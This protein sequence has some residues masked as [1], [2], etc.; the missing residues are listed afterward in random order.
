[1]LIGFVWSWVAVR[2]L[3]LWLCADRYVAAEL[4]VTRFIGKPR[5]SQARCWIEGVVHPG[6][7][8]VVTSD[9]DIAIKRFIAP[10]DGTRNEPL[11]HEI[12][13]QRL[14]VSHWP[15]HAGV[16]RWWHPPTVVSR[17]EIPSGGGVARNV[18]FGGAF[19]GVGL[20]CFRRGFRYLKAGPTDLRSAKGRIRRGELPTPACNALRSITGRSDLR[21]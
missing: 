16:K 4:E 11:P 17:G 6:G 3:R 8:R 5:N 2:Q 1:M 20:F 18:F 10:G 12:E 15:R 7:E 21:L 13:G 9:R 14:A 19:I